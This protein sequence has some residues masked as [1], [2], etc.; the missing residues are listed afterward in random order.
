VRL[1]LA[2]CL[3]ASAGFAGDTAIRLDDGVFRVTGWHAGGEP[4]DGWSSLL[5]IYAGEGDVPA[6]LGKYTV[7]EG[8]LAF[9]PRF[10]LSPGLRVRAVFQAPDGRVVRAVFEIPKAVPLAPTTR[11]ERV[12]PSADV[13]PANELKFY[14]VFSAPMARGE[15]WRHIHLLREDGSRVESPFLEIAEELWDR[16]HLRLTVLFDPGRIKRGL[17]SLAEAGPALEEGHRYTLAIDRD[18]L[19][20][21]GNPLVGEYRKPFRAGPADRVPPE[22]ST[23][24]IAAPKAGTTEPLVVRFPKPMDYALLQHSIAVAAPAPLDGTVTIAADETEWRFTPHER[25]AAGPG[26]L[27][28][29]TTLEDLAGN[30]IGRPFDVDTFDRVTKVVTA[31]TVDVPFRLR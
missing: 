11:V 4:A 15:A 26:R 23:W 24:K 18:W 8:T 21:R 12:F 2:L 10:P 25:W 31:E 17:A 30:H 5:S 6:L 16:E 27:I 19:D 3:L 13:L 29:Q 9:R 22:V 20:G 28:V 1:A 14:I 7:E